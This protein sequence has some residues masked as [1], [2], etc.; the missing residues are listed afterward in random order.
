MKKNLC[1][2][3]PLLLLACSDDVSPGG[4]DSS[5]DGINGSYTA[6]I[7]VGNRLYFVDEQNLYTADISD[8]KDIKV[9]DKQII[10]EDI[11]T[12]FH[13]EGLLFVG[14]GPAMYI[15]QLNE[16]GVP[17]R[18]SQTNYADF[19]GE[20][21]PCDPIV[22]DGEFAY[23]TLSSILPNENVGFLSCIRWQVINEL[24]IYDIRNIEKPVLVSRLNLHKP[25]GLALDGNILFVCDSEEG[26]KIFDVSD[27]SE[28]LELYHFED[29]HTYDAIA[30]NGLLVVAG[31]KSILQYDYS[32]I[33]NVVLLSK[34]DL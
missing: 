12:L 17:F 9:I 23:V 21:V 3:L 32:D 15:Y 30:R 34:Y 6:L 4:T 14:S 29:G 2:L 7:A 24:R 28:P 20:L 13:R 5:G 25:K 26:L 33:E 19:P 11:E 1:F 10:G 16:N 27:R 22:A 31:P 8:P 18:L